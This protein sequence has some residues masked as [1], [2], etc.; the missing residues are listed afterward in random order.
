MPWTDLSVTTPR[1]TLRPFRDADRDVIVRLLTDPIGREF[2]GGP[3]PVEEAEARSAGS[4]G[5][6]WGSFAIERNEDQVVIGS[7]NADDHR[8]EWE[9][10]YELLP[11]HWGHGYATEAVAALTDWA[12]AATGATHL[13][14]VTQAANER[15]WA[16]LERLGW[17]PAG[18][19]LEFGARQRRYRT[20]RSAA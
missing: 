12:F 11:E 6:T 7:C 16:L 18:E 15:S 5:V 8:G 3:V 13:I 14:A 17:L 20:Y 2:L 10:S 9:L 4:L 19:F 1:L